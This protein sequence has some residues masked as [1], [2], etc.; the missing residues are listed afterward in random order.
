VRQILSLIL[1]GTPVLA[2]AAID[3]TKKPVAHQTANPKAVPDS[4]GEAPA[5]SKPLVEKTKKAAPDCKFKDDVYSFDATS[6]WTINSTSDGFIKQLHAVIELKDTLKSLGFDDVD[7]YTGAPKGQLA[8]V[9]YVQN[10][11][12][13]ILRSELPIQLSSVQ[14]IDSG[15]S[16]TLSAQLKKKVKLGELGSNEAYK[17]LELEDYFLTVRSDQESKKVTVQLR[18]RVKSKHPGGM[19]SLA[20]SSKS[21]EKECAQSTLSSQVEHEEKLEDLLFRLTTEQ[22]SSK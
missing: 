10:K 1:L 16:F 13:R 12:T 14:K 20:L 18:R 19:A 9:K 22:I 3:P 2:K 5:D 6:E 17:S 4:L 8:F 7:A 21:F 15:E 11:G